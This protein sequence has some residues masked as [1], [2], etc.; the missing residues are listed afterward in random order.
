MFS[1]VNTINGLLKGWHDNCLL[2][3]DEY[4]YLKVDRPRYPCFY[5]LL[6]IQQDLPFPPGRPIVSGIGGPTER[7]SQ[8]VD[9]FLQPIVVNLPSYIRDTGHILSILGDIMWDPGMIMV[10]LD[11]VSLYTSIWN[12]LGVKAISHF[13]AKR[14]ASLWEHM[15]MLLAMTEVILQNIFFLFKEDWFRQTQGIAMGSRFSPAYANLF[16]GWLEE[17]MIWGPGGCH[18]NEHILYW[19]HFIDDCF[20]IWTG[21]G[22]EL[23]GF[24][25]YLNDNDVNIRLT[26]HFST[27][28]VVF[29]DVEL[30][31]KDNQIHSRMYRKPTSCNSLLHAASAH[32]RHQIKAI[33][34]GRWL[35]PDKIVVRSLTLC[36]VYRT[37]KDDSPKGATQDKMC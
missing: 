28:S 26:T 29:L 21:S 12:E 1:L 18:W 11:V 10:T 25:G 7:M 35:E 33:P 4:L 24:C 3:D 31:I 27:T 30:Y 37:W 15:Q 5:T 17:V 16:M 32:P 13:L 9:I 6:K 2:D 22:V 36:C 20:M 34:M 8:F 19:G 23:Q 14:T